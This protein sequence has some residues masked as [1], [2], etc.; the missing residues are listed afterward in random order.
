MRLKADL[1]LFAVAVIWGTG[2][3]S[4]GIAARYRVAYLFNGA[5]FML[6]GLL[7]IPFLPRKTKFSASQL[8][9]MGIAGTVLFLGS[10]L[11]Q[12][13]I[14]YTK[15]ANAG[16]ITSLY[17]VFTPFILWAIFREKPHWID[18]AAVSIASLGAY[19]LSTAGSF[20]L[21]PGDGYGIGPGD[22]G[23]SGGDHNSGN[24]KPGDDGEFVIFGRTHEPVSVFP[25]PTLGRLSWPNSTNWRPSSAR[26]PTSGST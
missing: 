23:K 14:L 18:L 1:T 15:V 21:Q 9:W 20:Q 2:F 19:L 10:A 24:V 16:F 26:S 12:V 25:I 3:I 22:H 5:S 13:G 4:Q 6:A 7:L 11:Q 8:A 17:T